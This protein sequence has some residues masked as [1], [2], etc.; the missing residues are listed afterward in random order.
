MHFLSPLL[1]LALTLSSSVLPTVVSA[2]R[3]G[4]LRLDSSNGLAKR[5]DEHSSSSASF[6]STA[7]AIEVTPT[8]LSNKVALGSGEVF[9]FASLNG[10]TT[11]GAGGAETTGD[12]DAIDV[13]SN[14]SILPSTGGGSDGLTGSGFRVKGTTNVIIRG[15]AI[16]KSPAPTDL[17]AVQ[18]GT[19]VWIDGNTFTADLDH[20]KDYYD[21]QVDLTHAA[22]FITVSNNVFQDS[23]KTSLVGHS[24]N[25]GD[26]DTGHLRVTYAYNH[27]YNVNSRLPS[28]RFGTGHVFY[29]QDVLGSGINSREGAEVLIEGNYFENVKKPVQSSL[30]NGGVVDGGDNTF[31]DSDEPDWSVEGS[32]SAADLGYEYD[33]KTSADIPALVASSAGAAKYGSS[34][35]SA[36]AATSTTSAAAAATSTSAEE[37]GD[38]EPESTSAASSAEVVESSTT[39]SA[40]EVAQ[41]SAPVKAATGE[42]FGFASLNGGTTGGAGGA[43]T[44]VSD[45]S[46]LRDAVEGDEAKVGDGEVVDVGSNTSILPSTGGGSD[47]LAGSGFRVKGTTNVIIR[48]LSLS[49]SPAPTDLILVQEGTNVWVDGNTFESD[50]DHDKDYYDGQFDCTHACDFVTVSNNIFQNAFKTS[51]VGHSDNN[52]DEDTGHLRVTYAYNLFSNVNSRL[53]SLRFGTGHIFYYKDILGSGINSREG[54]EVLIEGNYFENAKKPIESSLKN[55]GVVDG[56][57]NIFIDS[58]EPDWSVEGSISPSDLGY[59]YTLEAGADIPALVTAAAGAANYA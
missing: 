6:T 28:L 11:G 4:P 43:E 27:F 54:A 10:G 37:D 50:L 53:P 47:G 38:D 51:L 8:D 23:F 49:K 45:L 13:G 36:P 32:I 1:P 34:S 56:G 33:L 55:G 41:T 46:A 19:N 14:T 18:E 48:G 42:V 35:S 24:D 59:S 7:S 30:K 29:Y 21:G 3:T 12:G 58:D 15:L 25:N 17:I 5:C 40:A 31:I 9:G 2:G 44:T 16:S 57:D 22:D 39:T 20:D 52:G 26:E